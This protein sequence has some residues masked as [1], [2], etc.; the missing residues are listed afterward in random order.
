VEVDQPDT[1]NDWLSLL[2]NNWLDILFKLNAGFHGIQFDQL[3]GPNLLDIAILALMF[4]MN[5][6]LYVALRQTSRIW[7]MI[8]ASKPVLGMAL[9]IV[10]KLAGRG[11]V[12]GAGA[13]ISFVMLR[14]KVFWKVIASVGILASALLLVGDFGTTANSSSTI[15]A[16]LVGIGYVLL[17]AWFFLV[18]R[19][20]FQPGR[21][22]VKNDSRSNWNKRRLPINLFVK[23]WRKETVK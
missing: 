3:Y 14:S 19:R 16:T 20:L 21:G 17:M 6:G 1:T 23:G 12:M 10:T 18:G 11:G 15:V 8:A 13:V 22:G 9:F 4:I 7:S 2:Q 5:T